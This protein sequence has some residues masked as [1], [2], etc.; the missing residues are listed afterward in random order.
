MSLHPGAQEEYRR[1]HQPI[2]Q[3]LQDVLLSHGVRTY[4]IFLD[5]DTGDLFGYVEIEDAARWAA[6]AHTEVCRRWWRFMQPL[7]PTHADASPVS[8][9]L[10][11]VFHLS[12]PA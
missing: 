9:P 3:E 6:V 10:E 1:R 5:P 12:G 4:S 2:W 11:E 8:R 7:M